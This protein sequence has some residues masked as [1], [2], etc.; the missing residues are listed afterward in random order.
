MDRPV[1]LDTTCPPKP[2]PPPKPQGH[3]TLSKDAAEYFAQLDGW[4]MACAD[5]NEAIESILRPSKE[6]LRP[7]L[8]PPKNP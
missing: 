7:S 6:A 1:I 8:E 5:L 2:L 4:A 3:N